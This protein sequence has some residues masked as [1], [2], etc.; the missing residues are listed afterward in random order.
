MA[1][2]PKAKTYGGTSGKWYGNQV[3]QTG[4]QVVNNSMHKNHVL[5]FLE[6]NQGRIIHIAN[7]IVIVLTVFAARIVLKFCLWKIVFLMHIMPVL[8]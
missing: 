2:K 8:L 3:N 7:S 6:F 4:L 1:K 5:V